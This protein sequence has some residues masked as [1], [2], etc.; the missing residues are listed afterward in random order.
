MP[1][2]PT[3]ITVLLTVGRVLL[4]G[5][6]VSGGIGHLMSLPAMARNMGTHGVPSPMFALVSGTAFQIIAGTSLMLGLF[7]PLAALGLIVFTIASSAMM[8]NFWSMTGEQRINAIE[9]WQ[10]NI[11]VIGGLLIVIA[12]TLQKTAP[13]HLLSLFASRCAG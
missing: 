1:V 13:C 9:G 6:F 3:L 12:L 5:L 10:S 11:G 8:L 2:S 4:G 7:V